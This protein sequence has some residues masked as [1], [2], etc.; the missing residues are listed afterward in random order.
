MADK[1]HE[2]LTGDSF[3]RPDGKFDMTVEQVRRAYPDAEA[4]LGHATVL[5]IGWEMDN[6]AFVVVM[7]D[8]ERVLLTTSHGGIYEA[9]PEY[10]SAKVADYKRASDESAALLRLLSER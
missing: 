6:E 10:L 7:R 1:E 8:G 9:E 4:I 3:T 2:G 5:H